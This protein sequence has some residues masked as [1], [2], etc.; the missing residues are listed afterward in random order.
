MQ[1]PEK[2]SKSVPDKVQKVNPPAQV[3]M[4]KDGK[5]DMRRVIPAAKRLFGNK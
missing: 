2:M 4:R 1:T 5:S 3:P